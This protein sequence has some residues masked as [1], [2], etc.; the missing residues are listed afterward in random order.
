MKEHQLHLMK[1]Q[2]YQVQQAESL[3][4]GDLLEVLPHVRI[5]SPMAY[6]LLVGPRS[7]QRPEIAAFCEWLKGQAAITRQTSGEV[8][9][10]ETLANA[11]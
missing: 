2:Q 9:D 3:A 4:H 5:D 6:W 7:S 11:D 10:P 1:L 8:A